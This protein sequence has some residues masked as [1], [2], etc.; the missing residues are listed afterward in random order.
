MSATP[1]LNDEITLLIADL[2]QEKPRTKQEAVALY[3][4]IQV[5]LAEWLISELPPAEQKVALVA[6]LVGRQVSNCIKWF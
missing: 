2:V 4:K 3:H 1:T 6:M 5:K